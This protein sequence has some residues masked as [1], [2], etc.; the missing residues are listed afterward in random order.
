MIKVSC[1]KE[2]YKFNSYHLTKAFFAAEDVSFELNEAQSELIK[3]VKDGSV[4]VEIENAVDKLAAERDL[5]GQLSK[6]AGRHLPWGLLTGVR[7]VKLAVARI[8]KNPD[9]SREEFARWFAA[10]RLVSE[11]KAFL[12]WEIA[13][14]EIELIAKIIGGFPGDGTGDTESYSLYVH[15]PICPSIC[16][17]CSFSSGALSVWADR[18]DDYVD[19]LIKELSAAS[20]AFAHKKLTSIY[21]GGGTPTSLSAG[22]LTKLL[23]A[24]N[25]CYPVEDAA[26]FT[27]E[28][29]RP[30]SIDAEKLAAARAG[31][32]TR[33]SINPQTMRQRTLDAIGRKHTVADVTEKFRLARET[34]FDNINMDLIVGLPGEGVEDMEDTLRRITELSPDSLTVHSLAIKRAA[35]LERQQAEPAQ[36]ERM[37][38]L[39]SEYARHMRLTPYY[40]YRQKSIAGNFENV[41]YARAGK[42]SIYNVMIMQEAQSIVACGAG[43]SSKLILAH[44]VSNPGRPGRKTTLIRNV[45]TKSIAGYIERIDEIIA[46]KNFDN[47]ASPW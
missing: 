7:P 24:I 14:K 37:I 42:E 15:I 22:Q 2:S 32:V 25:M 46:Q 38:N 30:D 39:A 3:V 31:N 17:Y 23:S 1:N 12:A 43:A 19:A 33:I 36:I 29:G 11:E 34:G 47:P 18:L 16:S 4:I 45:N 10:E 5:Y 35:Q 41:G 6:V 40:L 26:E 44:P 13:K 9:G 8:L 27:L 20:T 28:A 21:I